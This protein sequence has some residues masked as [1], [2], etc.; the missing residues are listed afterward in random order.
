MPHDANNQ[1]HSGK[2]RRAWC[3]KSDGGEWR[4]TRSYLS[5][6]VGMTHG[7]KS[8]TRP[9]HFEGVQ[10]ARMEREVGNECSAE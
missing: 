7:K 6:M 3:V 5:L 9:A 10:Y 2:E 1:T 8:R 4:S